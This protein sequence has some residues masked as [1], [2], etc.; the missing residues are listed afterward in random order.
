MY[1]FLATIIIISVCF[2]CNE[3]KRSNDQGIDNTE[4]PDE[5]P[6]IL[7]DDKNTISIA[8]YKRNGDDIIQRLFNEALEKDQR[9]K[10]LTLRIENVEQFKNDSLENYQDYIT[11]NEAF[12]RTLERY[13]TQIQDSIMRNELNAMIKIVELKYEK[14]IAKHKSISELIKKR[15]SD[16]TD[17]VIAMKILVTEPMMANYMRNELPELKKIE[18][19][20]EVYDS[21]IKDVK[22]YT[23][24]KK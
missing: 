7:S 10:S 13:A 18:A 2:S 5:T 24:I 11:N 14:S 15:E 3:N 12:F 19:I 17:Q 21:L 20:V 16:L 1:K 8:S 22:P 4:K 9:L 6:D 23:S